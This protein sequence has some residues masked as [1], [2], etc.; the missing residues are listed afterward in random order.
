MYS[1][2]SDEKNGS[3]LLILDNADDRT[4]FE[5][6]TYPNG[7]EGDDAAKGESRQSPLSYLPQGRHGSILITSRDRS[8][9]EDFAGST[10]SIITV[11]ALDD[12]DSVELLRKRSSDWTSPD[13]YAERLVKSLDNIP[14]AIT[15]A[16][17]FVSGSGTSIEWFNNTLNEKGHH[18][19]QD[20][21]MGISVP[22]AMLRTWQLSF[23]VIRKKHRN[24]VKL[25]ALMSIFHNDDVPRF[26][27]LENMSEYNN[28]PARFLTDMTPLLRFNL[29]I[30]D[31]KNFDM[32]RLVQVAARSWLAN[33]HELHQRVREAR[34]LIANTMP[35]I[36]SGLESIKKCLALLPHASAALALDAGPEN[37]NQ[38]K[39]T[40]KLLYNMANCEYLTGDYRSALHHSITAKEIQSS[41]FPPD[42]QDA[43]KTTDLISR[44]RI[45]LGEGEKA[46]REVD[47]ELLLH[48]G[49][50]G[51]RLALLEERAR[52]TLDM[53]LGPGR[54][55]KVE[56]TKAEAQARHVLRLMSADIHVAENHRLDARRTLARA[57][58]FQGEP[59]Q[60]E[61]LLRQVLARRKQLWGLG[62]VD[63]LKS[64][65]D[66]GE[67][68]ARQG[69]FEEAIKCFERTVEGLRKFAPAKNA[70]ASQAE[71]ALQWAKE[72]SQ[73]GG[74]RVEREVRAW[75]RRTKMKVL[76]AKRV[77]VGVEERERMWIVRGLA[78]V[79]ALVVMMLSGLAGLSL[80]YREEVMGL[81]QRLRE[82]L[83]REDK[84]L[85]GKI[86][87]NQALDKGQDEEIQRLERVMLEQVTE[88]KAEI[89]RL[90]TKR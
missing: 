28:D 45:A 66:L 56:L 72:E 88:L 77:K 50:P 9:A 71:R 8:I 51:A 69:R 33:H 13:K 24:S 29:V 23:D 42:D 7:E 84:N 18:R 6:T 68:L 52:L 74:W 10:S 78:V 57:V 34:A 60:A 20:S 1:H 22:P 80:W 76:G 17:G 37:L 3:W 64:V 63:T 65:F 5:P 41:S 73:R 21:A 11:G 25:L 90:K 59:E 39:Q 4:L 75:G 62:H 70:L 82:E 26:L 85:L 89:Q 46:I 47:L 30:I 43:L 12:V 79:V 16:A 19:N 61:V 35:D 81:A 32:H 2:L 58:S 36:S 31:G 48:H 40:S 38:M 53:A 49:N 83:V 44:L 27:F 67:C 54:L 55:D 86:E 15:Q 14:L 87:H